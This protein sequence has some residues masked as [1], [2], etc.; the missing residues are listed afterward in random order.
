MRGK[1]YVLEGGEGCGKSTAIKLL[2]DIIKKAGHKVLITREPGGTGAAQEIRKI[3]L[4]SELKIDTITETLLILAA[5]RDHYKK[6]IK[7]A[8]ESG[9]IV[10]CDRFTDSTYVYQGCSKLDGLNIQ[11]INELHKEILEGFEFDKSFYLQLS[12]PLIGLNR[13]A[14]NSRETNS[15][16][17]R[18]LAFHNAVK[19]G[20]DSLYFQ[21][22][23]YN[24]EK[25]Y[26]INAEKSAEDIGREIYEYIR[27]D[28]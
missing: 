3:L 9:Y 24:A 26:I 11:L 27:C 21:Y 15:F 14:K 10:L 22:E 16:D 20:F 18:D 25:R 6:V 13:I 17:N 7:P 4:D 5:R 19:L 12:D 23:P 2:A 28:F 8:I 1:M